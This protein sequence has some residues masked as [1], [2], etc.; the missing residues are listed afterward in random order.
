FYDA[1]YGQKSEANV[2]GLFAVGEQAEVYQKMRGIERRDH[3][4][5]E[6]DRMFDGAATRSYLRHI[7]KDWS[8]ER[9]IRQ[10]YFADSGDSRLPPRMQRTVDGRLFFA[11]DTYT[12]GDDW[13]SVHSAVA[14]AREAID[15]LTGR[16]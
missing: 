7:E 1:S 10:A 3:L 9:F 8:A 15:R 12:G 14:S 6:L 4:L 16:D 13:G 2:L 11:G 5:A